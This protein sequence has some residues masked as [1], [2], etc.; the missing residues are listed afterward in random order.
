MKTST[1]KYLKHYI[2]AIF[3]RYR[4]V[5]HPLNIRGLATTKASTF[6]AG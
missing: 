5:K 3:H 6:K 2:I 1:K 4:Y